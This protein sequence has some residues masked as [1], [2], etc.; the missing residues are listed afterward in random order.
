M[1]I[2][3]T[4]PAR[5]SSSLFGP[6]NEGIGPRHL[7]G[8]LVGRKLPG[9]DDVGPGVDQDLLG[10]RMEQWT[11][12]HDTRALGSRGLLDRHDTSAATVL[13]RTFSADEVSAGRRTPSESC[14]P[15]YDVPFS[16]CLFADVEV[17][18]RS[19][20]QLVPRIADTAWV[21]EAA[22]VVGVSSSGR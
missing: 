6:A 7:L 18:I 12:E 22:Y 8:P 19:L 16:P 1:A 15:S 4:R 17:T 21:S 9:I 11:K 2:T 13:K 3:R 14:E 20:G 5:A 10:H